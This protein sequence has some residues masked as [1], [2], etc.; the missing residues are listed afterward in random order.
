MG[1]V[2]RQRPGLRPPRPGDA[3]RVPTTSRRRPL[4]RCGAAHHRQPWW[5]STRTDNPHPG[6]FDLSWPN[7]TCYWALSPATAIIE[8]TTDPDQVDEPV[9]SLDALAG[10]TVWEASEVPAARS[11]L[12]DTTRPSVPTLTGEIATVVP[13]TLAWAWA[14]AFHAE[15]R[16]GVLY[17]ARFAM[18]ES[19]ALFGEAGAP[20]A[21]PTSEPTPAMA[22]L[23]ALP[24]GFRAGLGTVG[25]LDA[26]DRAPAP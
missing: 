24:D 10:L 17:V 26:L 3:G 22:H 2:S 9:L 18:D 5:F 12:A 23:D 16:S 6:R 13:Y 14:D 4:F 25:D 21:S 11:R 1:T 19:V 15:G 20:A 8:R 7:G